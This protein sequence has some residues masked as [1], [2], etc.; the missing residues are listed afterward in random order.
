[1]CTIKLHAFVGTFNLHAFRLTPQTLETTM[2]STK[3][4]HRNGQ[5]C[6][7]GTFKLHALVGTFKLHALV[8]TFNLHAVV[9]TFKLHAVVG[10]F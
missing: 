9:C 2:H 3:L 1:M 8:G 5:M 7:I 10:I 6:R 4:R